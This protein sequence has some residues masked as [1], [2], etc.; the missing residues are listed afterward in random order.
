MIN[1]H[2]PLWSLGIGEGRD[3]GSGICG[4][5]GAAELCCLRGE[6]NGDGLAAFQ[7][8]GMSTLLLRNPY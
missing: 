3:G 5:N 1:R 2:L 6:C 4:R 7:Q 8:E